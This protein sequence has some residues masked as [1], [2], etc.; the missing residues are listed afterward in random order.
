MVASEAHGDV[1]PRLRASPAHPLSYHAT[2]SPIPPCRVLTLTLTLT[3]PP[4]RC[5]S[6]QRSWGVPLPAFYRKDSG[7]AL[8]DEESV[9]HVQAIVRVRARG[10]V[11]G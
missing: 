8:L 6:R 7:E 1:P 4:R 2:A 3:I 10:R 9:A 5:L 11:R